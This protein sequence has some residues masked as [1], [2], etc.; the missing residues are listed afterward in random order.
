[1]VPTQ[2]FPRAFPFNKEGTFP[3]YKLRPN[4]NY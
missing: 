1:M 3:N 4:L 2:D